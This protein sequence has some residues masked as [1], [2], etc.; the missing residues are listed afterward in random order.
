MIIN[1]KKWI[2]NDIQSKLIDK[3]KFLKENIYQW[4]QD[5]LN[6][7]FN[8]NYNEVEKWLN[9]NANLFDNEKGKENIYFLHYLGSHKPWLTSGMFQNSAHHYHKNFR[10]IDDAEYHIIHKWKTQSA[11]DFLI[12][13]FTLKVFKIDTP[14]RFF[15]T[16]FIFFCK[17]INN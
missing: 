4:D 17:T 6:S 10:K 16:V 12:A 2:E 1:Y 7:F 13:L 15:N 9:F 3:L 11:I 14:I 5:V 8:G